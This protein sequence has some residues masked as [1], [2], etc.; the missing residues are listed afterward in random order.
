MTDAM[1]GGRSP[2]SNEWLTSLALKVSGKIRNRI[3][4]WRG[5][6]RLLLADDAMLKDIGVSRGGIERVVRHGRPPRR[7]NFPE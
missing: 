2:N 1:D 6:R 5:E 4:V 7:R 3:E